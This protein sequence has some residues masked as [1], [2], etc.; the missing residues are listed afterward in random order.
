MKRFGPNPRADIRYTPRPGVYAILP[1]RGRI[2]ATFQGGIH[3]EYQLPGGGVDPGEQPISA[4]HREVFEETGWHIA[5][6]RVF[7]RFKSYVFMPDYNLWAE[8]ICTIYTAQPIYRH[9]EPL[10]LD[11]NPVELSVKDALR[12][13]AN[14]GDRDAISYFFKMHMGPFSRN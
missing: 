1:F 7:Y 14:A 12:R 6:P 3:N 2:L 4:L 8:K 5:K 10:E 13:L 11:H 9:S